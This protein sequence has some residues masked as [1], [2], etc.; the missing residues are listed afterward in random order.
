MSYLKDM[1]ET[2]DLGLR[3]A[4]ADMVARPTAFS[5]REPGEVAQ[6]STGY[7]YQIDVDAKMKQVDT[8]A[9]ALAHD[10]QTNVGDPV[11][12]KNYAAWLADWKAFYEQS[13]KLLAK[14]FSNPFR[15]KELDDQT[16]SYRQQL[17]GWYAD[18]RNQKGHDGRTPV[19]PPSG[20]P[21]VPAPTPPDG[22]G[23]G[24]SAG[25]PW[26]FWVLGGVGLV[27]LGYIA[28]KKYQEGVAKKH[29]LE[30]YAPG[31]VQKHLGP[32]AKPALEYSA[33]GRDP[34]L[35]NFYEGR[36]PARPSYS[37]GPSRDTPFQLSTYTRD[38]SP[39]S[40]V[41]RGFPVQQDEPDEM[42]FEEPQ[43]RLPS[44]QAWRSSSARDY[45][46]DLSREELLD[47]YDH[48]PAYMRDDE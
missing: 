34:E 24:A 26:W 25:L 22:R 33:A 12:Q 38:P 8:S 4:S 30:R 16:E 44:R 42:I 37:S 23:G 39:M 6:P 5:R 2:S 13:Q 20:Q 48:L 14:L 19:P 27:G 41:H 32:F 17:I 10:I 7:I 9:L 29:V 45:S 43:T 31:I 15:T 1:A 28:Y 46:R 35:P 11:F 36:S 40:A 21:P 47:E 3:F 18:Y